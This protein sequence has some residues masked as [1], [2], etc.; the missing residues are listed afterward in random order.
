[1][2]SKKRKYGD[3]SARALPSERQTGASADDAEQHTKFASE[4]P[5]QIEAED[6][7]GAPACSGA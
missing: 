5:D 7:T 3:L 2:T 6:T 1:M 4:S